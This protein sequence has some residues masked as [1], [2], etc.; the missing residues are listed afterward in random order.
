M[1]PRERAHVAVL[2][3]IALAVVVQV[4]ELGGVDRL[5]HRDAHVLVVE[6]RPVHAEREG[7]DCSA[8]NR[9]LHQLGVGLGECTALLEGERAP[10]HARQPTRPL[11][12][13]ATRASGSGIT[14]YLTSSA[15]GAG[16]RMQRVGVPVARVAGVGD[17]RSGHEVGEHER[18]GADHVAP[19]AHVAVCPDHLRGDHEIRAPVGAQDLVQGVERRR[20]CLDHERPAVRGFDRLVGDL[21]GLPPRRA[22]ALLGEFFQAPVALKREQHVVGVELASRPPRPCPASGCRG[23]CGTCRS[24]I[25]RHLPALGQLSGRFGKADVARRLAAGAC[26]ERPSSGRRAARTPVPAR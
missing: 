21:A 4:V 20:V 18:A 26:P 22:A 6:R 5:L 7:G 17:R 9:H 2:G 8:G 13:A 24:E 25:G 3:G 1:P 11:R 10:V 15:Y 14:K 12:N 23:G 16:C 19:V